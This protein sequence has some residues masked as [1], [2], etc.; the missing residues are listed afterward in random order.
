MLVLTWF[1]VPRGVM[2]NQPPIFLGGQ[3]G[4]VGPLM[5]EYGTVVAAGTIVRK[6]ILRQNTML[7]GHPSPSKSIPFHQGLYLNLRRVVRLNTIYIANLLALRRWYLDVRSR[8]LSND[9]MEKALHGGAVEK[10]DS[11]INERLKRLGDVADR[12][13]CALETPGDAAEGPSDRTTSGKKEFFE[14]WPEME[15]AFRDFLTEEGDIPKRD[16]F[17]VIL[18]KALVR[19]GK[20]YI[21]AIKGLTGEESEAGVSW[22]QGFID[23]ICLSV[24]SK[25]PGM[26]I[27]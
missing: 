7:L 17:L 18:E 26:N 23:D 2:M 16:R 11:A 6:D 3:G 14:R 13:Q 24:W 4:L 1:D 10:L 19:D 20:D 22:L 8:F 27:S 12:M 21:R 15:Q 9:D 25:I 5:L